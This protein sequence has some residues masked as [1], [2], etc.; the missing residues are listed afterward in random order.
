MAVG[1]SLFIVFPQ[2][3]NS[4][5]LGSLVLLCKLAP[6]SRAT[7]LQELARS[8]HRTITSSF[9]VPSDRR[10]STLS[11]LRKRNLSRKYKLSA[12]TLVIEAQDWLLAA[13]DLPSRT[14]SEKEDVTGTIEL[15]TQLG[16]LW[17][18][19]YQRTW[20]GDLLAENSGDVVTSFRVGDRANNPYALTTIQR[21]IL[22]FLVLGRDRTFLRFL[23]KALLGFSGSIGIPELITAVQNSFDEFVVSLR[24]E[25]G[26]PEDQETL[27]TLGELR[28]QLLREAAGRKA[29]ARRAAVTV[30]TLRRSYE[31]LL[32]WRLESLVDLQYLRK[33]DP[34]GY[35]Y[36]CTDSLRGLSTLLDNSY[37]DMFFQHWWRCLGYLPE[38]ANIDRAR[39]LLLAANKARSNAMGYTLIREGAVV[40]NLSALRD[41]RSEVVEIGVAL[42]AIKKGSDEKLKVLVSVDRNRTIAAYKMVAL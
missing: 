38:P 40:A 30:Q 23:V 24:P 21:T 13:D 32:Y 19:T 3:K 29:S 15:A 17:P 26:G 9:S 35:I 5:R 1:R 18:A 36:S 41:G 6:P 31:E 2:S 14:G 12:T 25:A 16:L 22:A 37:D 33:A 20:A 10:E 28:T 8:Y 34:D 4:Q 11:F 27:K 39:L 42:G 7:S